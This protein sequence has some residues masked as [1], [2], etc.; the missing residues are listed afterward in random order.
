VRRLAGHL[1][2]LCSA[3][4]L[5]LCA[6]VVVLWVRGCFVAAD[7]FGWRSRTG[8]GNND[9]FVFVAI[10]SETG[11]IVLFRRTMMSGEQGFMWN[12]FAL[13]TGGAEYPI[14]R[15]IRPE[16]G[17]ETLALPNWFLCLLSVPLP[18]VY[19][20]VF[21]SRR[22]RHQPGLCKN[23]GYDMRA[24]SERCPECGTQP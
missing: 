5:L 3:I 4:S 19:A 1:F 11:R 17:Q 9:R 12:A 20:V 8:S 22:Q 15:L 24:T 21:A 10:H 13:P 7:Q 14:F 23:C 6:A 16:A 18:G 2:T